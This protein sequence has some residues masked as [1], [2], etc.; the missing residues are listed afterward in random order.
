MV[1]AYIVKYGGSVLVFWI[2]GLFVDYADETQMGK[3]FQGDWG[4]VRVFSE[5]VWGYVKWVTVWVIWI[6]IYSS[7]LGLFVEV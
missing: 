4:V 5:S 6:N 3:E 7:I 1:K 2:C